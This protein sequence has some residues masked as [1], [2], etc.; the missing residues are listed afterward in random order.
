MKRLIPLLLIS[1]TACLKPDT[2]EGIAPVLSPL[3]VSS[4][5]ASK[6]QAVLFSLP[7]DAP[8]NVNWSVTPGTA[9]QVTAGT[10]GAQIL[11]GQAGYYY[12][13]AAYVLNGVDSVADTAHITVSDSVYVPPIITGVDTIS[14]DGAQLAITPQV[15]NDT[16]QV[17]SL[18]VQTVNTYE[19]FPTMI[20]ST[21]SAPGWTGGISADFTAVVQ[22]STTPCSY[23]NP[24]DAYLFPNSQSLPADGTYPL[25]IQ[26]GTTVYT[27]SITVT[28][29]TYVFNWTY[30][31]GVTI[32]PTTVAR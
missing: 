24:A 19:C 22:G 28:D 9:V 2:Q 5:T 23:S 3:T 11:F 12:I 10:G 8:S 17:L 16:T 25:T 18:F 7:A 31:S 15:N 6:G 30:T 13:R 29:T 32:S 4:S 20:Y 14:I 21:S 26:V 1:A 27:G